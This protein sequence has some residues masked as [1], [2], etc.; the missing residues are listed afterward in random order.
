MSDY[1]PNVC[2]ERHQAISLRL[3]DIEHTLHRNGLCS[4]VEVIASKVEGLPKLTAFMYK[5]MGALIL[6]QFTVP[7]VVALV[8][9]WRAN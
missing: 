7:V 8:V 1:D 3:T 6:L 5:A 2:L 9:K 4:K